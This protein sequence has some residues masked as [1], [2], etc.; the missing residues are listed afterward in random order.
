MYPAGLNS[1]PE[2][3]DLMNKIAGVIPSKWRNIGL[4][5]GVD[6]DVLEGIASRRLE[7]YSLCYSDVFSRWKSNNSAT[8]PYIWATVVQVLQAPAVDEQGLA[9][10]IKDELTENSSQ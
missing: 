3:P 5:L 7:D 6:K 1:E 9:K 4:Q 8:H 2:L 10:K